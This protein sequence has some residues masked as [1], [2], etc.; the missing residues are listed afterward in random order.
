MYFLKAQYLSKEIKYTIPKKIHSVKSI[1][2][3]SHIFIF[4]E[5]Q[6]TSFIFNPRFLYDLKRKVCV[7]KS[8]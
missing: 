8:V 3:R 7:A 6:L 2:Q 1:L 5:L 4:C